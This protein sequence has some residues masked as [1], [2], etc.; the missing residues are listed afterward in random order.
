MGEPR[1][2]PDPAPCCCRVHDLVHEQVRQR[3]D[4]CA[5]REAVSGRS[6]TYRELWQRSGRLAGQLVDLGVRPGD[7]VAVD[8]GRSAELVVTLLGVV[9]A[10]AAYLPLD[11]HA[12]LERTAGI[13][14][15]ARTDIVVRSASADTAAPHL[16]E[17][18]QQVVPP[19]PGSSGPEAP[20]D[21]VVCADDPVYVAYTSGST[22]RPKGVVIPH[23]AVIRLVQEPVHCTIEPGERVANAS[24]PAFDA[25]TFE[26]WSSLTAGGTVVV[27]PTVT[28]LALDAWVDLVRAERITSMFLTT[29]LFHMV[30]REQPG[31]FHGLRTLVV[32]GEQLD[33]ATTRRV[34]A[35]G[36]PGR[37]VNGYGPTE[38]TTFATYFDCTLDSLAGLDRVPI[39]FPLQRTR[40]QVLDGDLRP[41]PPG[42]PGELCIGG[43]GVGLGYLHRPDLTAERFVADGLSGERM[44]RTGDIVRRLPG[45]ALSL[46]GRRDRQIKM[47]G[48]RIELEEVERAVVGTGL[49]HSAFVEKLGDGPSAS[50]I[51]WVLPTSAGGPA[52]LLDPAELAEELRARLAHRLPSYMVPARWMVL[53]ELPYGPTGKV[54]RARLLARL[55]TADDPPGADGTPAA[56]PVPAELARIWCEVLEVATAHPGDA[57]LDLGGNSILAV[58]LAS[59]IGERLGVPLEPADVLLA[60]SLAD[61]GA[62][63]ADRRPAAVPH[64]SHW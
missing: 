25:T 36:P 24:N 6:L 15:E 5:V 16:P 20:V 4:S 53:D 11:A 37:L 23:R 51:C 43:P 55:D 2:V 56:S 64:G 27:L 39:G 41:V 10:G 46:I 9:R 34:L 58:Q 61:L 8:Q 38:T 13:L 42:E 35:E 21:V 3:G 17:G 59:R 14:E 54:D 63:V 31:A 33:L 7:V 1:I 50:L 47:R 22:G 28:D 12:P 57:F 52:E 45:G 26:I 60:D 40:L 44:Y 30:A 49:V 62:R 29:S 19:E 18:L 32:G 48:F